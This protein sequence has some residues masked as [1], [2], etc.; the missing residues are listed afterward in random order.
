MEVRSRR[1]NVTQARHA[2]NFGWPPTQWMKNT[3]ALKQIAADVDPLMARDASE[4]FERVIAFQLRWSKC[5][6]VATKPAIEP[7][8]WGEQRA[9]KCYERIQNTVAIGVA[10][11]GDA[12]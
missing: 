3:Y 6:R 12:K 7:T 9:F 11:V 4:R 5:G 8:I 2:H 1:C 10:L